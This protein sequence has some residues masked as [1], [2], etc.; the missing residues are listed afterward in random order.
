MTKTQIQKVFAAIALMAIATTNFGAANA[1]QIGTGSVVGSGAFD[2]VINWDDAFPGTASGSVAN[3]LIKARV[4]PTLNMAI[5]V[6]EINLGVL[7]ASIAST[8]S[9]AIEVGTNAVSGVTVTARS[10]SGGLTNVADN[11]VQIN[12]LTADGIGENYTWASNIG[13]SDSSY[14]AYAA[15]NTGANGLDTAKEI[16]ENSTE[17]NVF[18][19]NKPETT[20]GTIDDVTFDVSATSTIET[21]AGDYEDRVTFTVTG[22]F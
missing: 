7:V 11:S 8:G 2:T 14:T 21:P 12:S 18:T 6:E 19:T 10:Q 13:T 4:N 20:S 17:Y 3:I 1:T 9:L 16:T 5:S 15:V 22:N